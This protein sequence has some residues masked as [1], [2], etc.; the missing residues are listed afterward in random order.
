MQACPLWGLPLLLL[1]YV[2]KDNTLC[3]MLQVFMQLFTPPL[4]LFNI[5]TRSLPISNHNGIVGQY[6]FMFFIQGAYGA[7][8]GFLAHAEAL[9][10]ILGR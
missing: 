3:V 6:Y 9:L 8:E 10:N 7:L 5:A 4:R 2:C 1:H